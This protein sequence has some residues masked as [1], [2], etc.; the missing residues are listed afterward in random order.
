MISKTYIQ[1][2]INSSL[3]EPV[4]S[5]DL[6]ADLTASTAVSNDANTKVFNI[7]LF[8]I[9]G[10]EAWPR[11]HRNTS[12]MFEA[13][14]VNVRVEKSNSVL[15]EGMEGSILPIAVA[16]GEGRVVTSADNL[17]ALNAGNQVILRYVDS[18]GNPTQ[19]YPMNPN[20]SPEA[21][22]GVTSKDGRATIMM[23]HPERNFR[24]VQHSW[25]PEEWT[26]DGAWLRMFRNA[27]KFIG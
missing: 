11:F 26:E 17:A 21:I 16:H 22:S 9:P 15:L 24:A 27:R 10:A 6:L 23:P 13:R 20:G 2:F 18:Q 19:H 7:F 4:Q 12:E 3:R 5:R 8:A 25:K 1:G 14:A